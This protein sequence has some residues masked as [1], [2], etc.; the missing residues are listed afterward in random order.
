[1]TIS[2]RSAE[3]RSWPYKLLPIFPTLF[4]SNS[5]SNHFTAG[6]QCAAWPKP[7]SNFSSRWQVRKI[8]NNLSLHWKNNYVRRREQ[9]RTVITRKTGAADPKTQR[10]Q[11]RRA[12]RC[13]S[14]AAASYWC[15]EKLGKLLLHDRNPWKFRQH[16]IARTRITATRAGTDPDQ[17]QSRQPEFSRPDDRDEHVPADAGCS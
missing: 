5:R 3:T 12:S 8:S 4:R 16:P 10:R 9:D 13:P 6:R 17:G 7:C 11:W 14:C 15:G 2:L 1:M